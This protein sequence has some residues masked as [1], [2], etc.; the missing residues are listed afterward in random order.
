[1]ISAASH[2][3]PF[4]TSVGGVRLPFMAIM[5]ARQFCESSEEV[6]NYVISFIGLFVKLGPQKLNF[7][8]STLSKS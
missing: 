6:T 3:T 8:V 7:D 1:M 4:V 5:T 2:K